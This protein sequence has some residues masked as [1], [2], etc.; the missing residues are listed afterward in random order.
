M[1]AMLPIAVCVAH[2]QPI[3]AAGL[4][5]V[6]H[7][8]SDLRVRRLCASVL[9]ASAP[10]SLGQVLVTD[11]DAGMS[12]LEG[13]AHERAHAGPKVLLVTGQ[14]REWAVRAALRAG[15]FGFLP[16][17]CDVAE[18]VAAVRSLAQGVHF[19]SEAIAQRVAQALAREELTHREAD[20][21]GLIAVGA[22]NKTIAAQLG[23]T[24]GTVKTH[25]QC[26]LDKLGVPTRTHAALL[27]QDLGL[28]PAGVLRGARRAL[29][30]APAALQLQ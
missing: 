24:V 7:A 26:I 27:A 25:V 1:S 16:M 21:L 22:C 19:L 14:D 13:A 8:C 6:L 30:A 17:G 9:H 3:V 18:L 4:L 29:G 28:S 5:S 2:A 15:A 20:V 23:I 11:Y 12:F 10:E